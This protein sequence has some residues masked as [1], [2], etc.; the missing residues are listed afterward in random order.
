[1]DKLYKTGSAGRNLLILCGILA[2]V[3]A[4]IAVNFYIRKSP[5]VENTLKAIPQT[6]ADIKP[7][8]K[9]ST[10]LA[11]NGK[12][13]LIVKEERG[14][15]G[16]SIDT[17]STKKDTGETVEIYTEVLSEGVSISVP[18]NTFSPDNKYIFLKRTTQS[19]DTFF[20]LKTD[21]TLFKNNEKTID[22][23][24]LF[25][26]KYPETK[27]SDVTGWGGMTLIVVNVNKPDG[28]VEH[29][30]WYDVTSN[31]FIALSTRFD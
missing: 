29:S 5:V 11:P 26:Q 21:G 14:K 7:G 1:M 22:F 6:F 25:N 2:L 28:R 12:M 15:N 9:T 30:Y 27:A 4:L 24:S 20:V 19:G 23:V 10:I 17:F 8:P 3:G 13:T 18:L 16:E 31:S